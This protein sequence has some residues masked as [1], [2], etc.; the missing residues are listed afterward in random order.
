MS[1]PPPPLGARPHAGGTTFGVWA[2]NATAVLVRLVASSRSVAMTS[3]PGGYWF[4][5]IPAVAPGER[6]QYIIED[7]GAVVGARVDPYA[8]EVD[9]VGQDRSAVVYDELAFNWGQN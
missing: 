4:V 2:P 3:Q 7:A 1:A 9:V 6:Y 8:R 5:D